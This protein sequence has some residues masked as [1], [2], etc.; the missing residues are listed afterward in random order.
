MASAVEGTG[1]PTGSEHLTKAVDGLSAADRRR[2][3]RGWT[4]GAL[5]AL[6]LYTWMLTAGRFNF[7]RKRVF[8]GLFDA[9]ARAL[10]DGHWNVSPK[11]AL[12]EGFE[13]DGKTY[14]YFGP[15]PAVIRMPILAVTD[16]FD[17]RLAALSMLVAMGILAVA[18]FRLVCVLRAAVR[19]DAAVTQG[20]VR[21]TS[22]LAVAALLAPPFFLASATIVYHEATLWGVALAVAAFNSVARWQREPDRK[23]LAVAVAA[24]SLAMLSRQSIAFGPLLALG[25]VGLLR[26]I[27][28]YRDQ[29]AAVVPLERVRRL[30]PALRTGALALILAAGPS[31][32]VH[33]AKFGEPFSIPVDRQEHSQRD[34]H[35][36]QV[37][38]DNPNMMGPEYLLTTTSAYLRPHGISVRDELPW[39]DFPEEQPRVLFPNPTF[40]T[41][42]W[43]SS[44]PATAPALLAL[45]LGA[46]WAACRRRLPRPDA[47]PP[48]APLAA[49][50]AV[51]MLGVLMIA[52]VANRYLVD[53]YPL[54]LIG[55]TIGF[56]ALLSS[57]PQWRSALRRGA[58][59]GLGILVAFGSLTNVA[60]ALSYQRA[61]GHDILEDWH[62]EYI[63]WRLNL[64]GSTWVVHRD[65]LTA[66]DRLPEADGFRDGELLVIGDCE[67]V[68]VAVSN[69]DPRP[70][71]SRVKLMQVEAAPDDSLCRDALD[72]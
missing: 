15:L 71:A 17:G 36:Q 20:E 25:L 22:L 2:L 32:L 64:P 63:G 34:E 42:D 57:I 28:H 51:S 47:G 19:G 10:F 70:D 31:V 13:L 11:A 65:D 33:Y 72:Q 62:A 59:V 52:Y 29:E 69:R 21:L 26:L 43:A 38:A 60:L 68:Y 4:A 30:A 53:F 12:F 5:P 67:S 7:G 23:R 3:R 39:I 14:I 24:I 48:L 40:D 18:A 46:L 50:A 41:R 61:R 45:S 49:G 58:L 1:R 66:D 44:L 8:S 54:V 56:H 16:A 55:G 27:G 6:A 9:Q 35:R 37:L